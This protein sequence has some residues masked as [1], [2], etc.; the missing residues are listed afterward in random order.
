[1]ATNSLA[2]IWLPLHT[3]SVYSTEMSTSWL[4][5]LLP[6]T[7]SPFRCIY[8]CVAQH[9]HVSN[10]CTFP[11]LRLIMLYVWHIPTWVWPDYRIWSSKCGSRATPNCHAQLAHSLLHT[12][13]KLKNYYLMTEQ[14][15]LYHIALSVETHNSLLSRE[16]TE[17]LHVFLQAWY[18]SL[19]HP[20]LNNYIILIN[21]CIV[22]FVAQLWLTQSFVVIFR[23]VDGYWPT[24]RCSQVGKPSCAVYYHSFIIHHPIS[25]CTCNT[26]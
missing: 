2:H 24:S 9:L 21:H 19:H 26:H 23:D 22:I 16:S 13:Y 20:S 14:F 15:L 17:S 4:L 25:T 7:F 6:L 11:T 10:I 18:S 8:W 1:M 12:T 5:K 3:S